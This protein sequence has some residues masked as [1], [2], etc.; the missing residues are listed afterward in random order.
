MKFKVL[1][2]GKIVGAIEREPIWCSATHFQL[3]DGRRAACLYELWWIDDDG[4][5]IS[6]S[7]DGYIDVM[8]ATRLER[9][10]VL[11]RDQ[12]DIVGKL[13]GWVRL[14]PKRIIDV[15]WTLGDP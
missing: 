4:N 12:R 3:E 8:P 15:P 9:F 10:L 13:P 7:D 11:H 1:L 5:P 14:P 2:D 6:R